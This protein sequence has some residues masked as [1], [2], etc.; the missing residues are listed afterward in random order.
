MWSQMRPLNPHLSDAELHKYIQKQLDLAADP[1]YQFANK[2]SDVFSAQVVPIVIFSHALCEAFI[3][4]ALALGLHHASKDGV[5]SLTEKTEIKEKWVNGPTIFLES[6]SLP[7]G[8][9]I[10]ETLSALC[11]ERNAY[12]HH[13]IGLVNDAGHVIHERNKFARILVDGSGTKKIEKYL[14]LPFSLLKNLCVQTTDTDLR[15]RFEGIASRY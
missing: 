8:G 6:Y 5:F 1:Q 4:A 14:N 9:A 12:T 11:K 7:K 10:F 13:K 2:F 15:F 3:N